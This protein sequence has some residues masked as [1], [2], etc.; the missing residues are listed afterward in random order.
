MEFI[1]TWH[2]SMNTGLG[3]MS[4]LAGGQ[5]QGSACSKKTIH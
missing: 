2:I 1:S 5:N 4:D 3:C